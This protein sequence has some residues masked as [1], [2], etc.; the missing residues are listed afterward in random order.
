MNILWIVLA[1]IVL[2]GV[3]LCLYVYRKNALFLPGLLGITG[4]PR[5]RESAWYDE[6]HRFRIG[7]AEDKMAFFMEHPVFGG[8]RHMYFNAEDHVLKGIAPVR[9]R[10]FQKAQGRAD[11]IDAALE[12]FNYLTAQAEKGKAWLI[13]DLHTRE[14]IS[15]N[16]NLSHLT[17]MFY[18]GEKGKPLAV[19][20]PGGGFISNVT[21]CE[22]Y[23]IA[24]RL[25]QMGYSVLVVS[26]PV[27][28]QLG[29]TEQEKQGK[30][31]AR[32][33]TQ[34][35]RYLTAHQRELSISMEDYAIFGF[36]AGGLMTT[37]FSFAGYEDC[38]LK[39]GL[40]RPKAIFPMY[41]LDWNIKALPVDKGLSVFS[42]VGR[43]DEFGFGKVEDKLP[44]LK[45]MLGKENVFVRI[46]DDLGHGF[47]IG[48][49]TKVKGW[50]QEAV[51][52]WEKHR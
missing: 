34:V 18:Q 43:K 10:H 38:W 49:E 4:F 24:M 52:F 33:L 15:Q 23:P 32:E 9:Y 12:A 26:Y 51:A 8:F 44:A 27:G 2:L 30:A 6:N 36:S 47:G 28:K 37:A 11:Q 42:I 21:D 39:H 46:I 19:V 48:N 16:Q 14:E 13:S 31:A 35:I 17:G 29:E 20:V 50:L 7:T 22:G 40:P 45:E 41:G 5:I 1:L 3:G 25:H